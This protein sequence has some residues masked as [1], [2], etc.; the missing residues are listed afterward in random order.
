MAAGKGHKRKTR[1][2]RRICEAREVP[3]A[4][5]REFDGRGHQ[6]DD[7][8]SGVAHDIVRLEGDES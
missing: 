3:H 5:V 7:D 6:L 2:W 4:T 8:L 1:K